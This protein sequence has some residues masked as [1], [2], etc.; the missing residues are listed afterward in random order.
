MR[1]GIIGA[2]GWLGGALTRA[3]IAGGLGPAT[4]LVLLN[5]SGA[6][7]AE[8]DHPRIGWAKDVDDLVARSDAVVLSVRPEDFA[9]L[10]LRAP[11]RLVVSLMAGVPLAALEEMIGG[12]VVRAM[13]NA[14]A[15]LNRSYTPWLAGAEV[16]QEDRAFVRALLV[17]IGTEDEVRDEGQIDYLTALSGSGAAYPALLAAALLSH[18]HA[19]GLPDRVALRAVEA[20]VCDGADLLRTRIGSA[21]D[22]VEAYRAYR[23]TTAAGLDA[24]EKGGFSDSVA[25][26]LEAATQ[27]AGR[28]WTGQGT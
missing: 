27:K 24:A 26:A 19:T 22:L 17:R 13:P 7:P 3:L 23:G 5:R 25:S 16:T 4:D 8:F 18:A 9:A 21:P 1:L 20:V 14:A 11:G 2:T 6:R 12:R 15:E 10:H 28:M